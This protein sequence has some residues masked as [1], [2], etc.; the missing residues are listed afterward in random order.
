MTHTSIFSKVFGD[1]VPESPS[2][3]VI[4]EARRRQRRRRLAV[5]A[6]LAIAAVAYFAAHHN[7]G[8]KTTAPSSLQA[9]AQ[10]TPQ[11]TISCLT[12]HHVLATP[13]KTSPEFLKAPALQVSFAL[14]PGQR[15]DALTI[16][17]ERDAAT[18]KNVIAD[19]ARRFPTVRIARSYFTQKDNAVAFWNTPTR[20][21]AS[22]MTVSRCL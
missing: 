13:T 8:G 14:I 18:A 16:Y 12:A 3:A 9:R 4:E 5:V 6:I 21:R 7:W 2:E 19:L 11:Q 20:A 15:Q 17:F 22:D 1:L 10:V